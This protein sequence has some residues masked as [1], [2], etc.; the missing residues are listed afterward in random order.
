M[1]ILCCLLDGPAP[2][3]F[4]DASYCF[5]H[6]VTVVGADVPED[7]LGGLQEVAKLS[8]TSTSRVLYHIGDAP[9]HGSEF[10]TLRDQFEHGCPGGHN[11]QDLLMSLKQL[12][13]QYFFGKLSRQTDMMISK[14]NELVSGGTPSEL[15]EY[16]TSTPMTDNTMMSVITK[17]ITGTLSVSISN[18]SG[19]AQDASD[20]NTLKDYVFNEYFP[21]RE[22]WSTIDCERVHQYLL[23]MPMSIHEL[24]T[25]KQD[26]DCLID[27]PVEIEVKCAPNPFARGELRVAFYAQQS[28]ANPCPASSS[29]EYDSSSSAT[30]GSHDGNGS[31][32]VIHKETRSALASEQTREK[33][34]E[35]LACHRAAM[36]LAMEFN[37]VRPYESDGVEYCD[38]S[39]LQHMTRHGQPFCTQETMV[40]GA[41]EKYN[42][43]SGLCM[44]CPTALNTNHEIVQTF[45]HWTH[46]ITGG[47]I[48]VVD[49][50][51]AFDTDRK[52][53]VLS[54]PA[55][56]CQNPLRFGLTN[57]ADS[58]FKKFY[59]THYCNDLCRELHLPDTPHPYV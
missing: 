39:I 57:L 20:K 1:N 24:V 34:E 10:H 30:D 17:S 5:V 49:C 2:L 37:K 19:R 47:K 32:T 15:A 58:G 56:H 8:W 53:F 41:W 21:S 45:S 59:A 23:K 3:G 54:D 29:V 25:D 27:F 11:V 33:Y 16:I 9:C 22:V 50:Q 44:P 12:D 38:V 31:L 36:Y 7:V 4:V 40:Q 18:C 28:I 35:T 13:I 14:F 26:V 42:N 43:N 51:G 48:M 52:T 6:V 46:H 55:I